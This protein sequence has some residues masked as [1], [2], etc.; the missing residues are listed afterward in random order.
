MA[1]SVNK[2]ILVGNVGKDP[3]VRNLNDGSKVVSFPLATSEFWK[4]KATGERKDK[5]E[6]HKI[7]IF[8]ANLADFAGKYLKKGMKVYAE[9]QLQTRKWQDQNGIERYTTE[10]VIARF[11]GDLSILESKNE[12]SSS[13]ESES[14]NTFSSNDSIESDDIPF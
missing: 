7:V 13:S 6:W 12:A 4:D 5:T 9:G 14:E 11:R 10:I 1:G 3:D 2:V 8:N